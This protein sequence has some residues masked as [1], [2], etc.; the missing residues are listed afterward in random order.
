MTPDTT[1]AAPAREHPPPSPTHTPTLTPTPTPTHTNTHTHTLS[2]PQSLSCSSALN[3]AAAQRVKSPAAMTW[4]GRARTGALLVSGARR[5]AHTMAARG[6]ADLCRHYPCSPPSRAASCVCRLRGLRN[7]M[8]FPSK[9]L[10]RVAAPLPAPMLLLGFPGHLSDLVVLPC[11][12]V[13]QIR[14]F[15][16]AGVA[17]AVP[18]AAARPRGA[19]LD[20]PGSGRHQAI[21]QVAAGK[22]AGRQRAAAACG[23]Y[24]APR[25][26]V[27]PAKAAAQRPG[28]CCLADGPLPFLL[29]PH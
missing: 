15:G 21:A 26:Q 27:I 18:G 9:H 3:A 28:E 24:R 12:R 22:V 17:R 29:S 5:D 19:R 4:W 11:I 8:R 16:E 20:D 1:S 6:G 7:K 13:F 25:Q 10:C 14:A 2:A 23:D